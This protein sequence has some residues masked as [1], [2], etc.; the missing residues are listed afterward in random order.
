MG[1]ALK[2]YPVPFPFGMLMRGNSLSKISLPEAI[3]QHLFL[4]LTTQLGECRFDPDYSSIVWEYDFEQVFTLSSWQNRA[5]ESIKEVL[6]CR[7]PRLTDI[8]VKVAVDEEEWQTG[9]P[10]PG[11]SISRVK[12]RIRISVSGRLQ[13]TNEQADFPDYTIFFS[14][15]SLD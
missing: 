8:K 14:P 10:V 11:R 5:E 2:Y 15:I 4:V 12:K 1:E 9:D 3:R 6:T 7:E 13:A